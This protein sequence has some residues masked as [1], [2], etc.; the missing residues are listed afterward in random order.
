MADYITL[1]GAET[2]QRAARTMSGAADNIQRAASHME[3]AMES[4]QRFMNDWLD[5]LQQVLEQ[6]REAR[7]TDAEQHR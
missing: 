6:D 1:I 3:S 7:K 2:V 4:H 5:R